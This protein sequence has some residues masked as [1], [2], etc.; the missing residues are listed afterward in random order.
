MNASRQA[1][2]LC[3]AIAVAFV[4][5]IVVSHGHY[6]ATWDERFYLESGRSYVAHFFDMDGLVEVVNMPHL[7]THG[8][9]I[10]GIYAALL[11]GTGEDGSF[12]RLHLVK[13]LCSAL[14]LL[15]VWGAARR[16]ESEASTPVAAMLL[17]VFLPAWS[18]QIYD[19]HMD[20]SA[21]LLYAA[22]ILLA[23]QL[24]VGHAA[25]EQG[26]PPSL[27]LVVGFGAL[28]AIA[29]SHRAPLAVVPGA[30]FLLLAGRAFATGQARRW[31]PRALCFVVVFFLVLWVVDPYLRLHGPVGLFEKLYYAAHAPGV[32]A[33]L[34]RYDGQIFRAA[35]LPRSYLPRWML[36]SIPTMTLALL[37]LGVV[38]LVTRLRR[39]APTTGQLVAAFL[40][41]SLLL[42]LFAAV[43]VK[44]TIFAAWRHFLFL[45][46][47]IA[48]IA[49]LG[50]GQ[51]QAWLAPRW[52][53][54]IA[55]G[56][57]AGLLWIGVGMLRLHPY[58]SLYI[59]A[60][61]GGLPG[62][63]GRF[64]ADYWGRSYKEAAEWIE[65][66]GT[67]GAA[68]ISVH[69]CGPAWVIDY[70]L[71]AGYVL[72]ADLAAADYVVCFMRPGF[73]AP[74]EPPAHTIERDGVPLA[75]VWER[76]TPARD[77]S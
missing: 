6:G 1:R 61:Q 19:N 11:D 40:L 34:V 14:V 56:F 42:P 22:L 20:G 77:D 64:E 76:R 17:L 72:S 9:L 51:L 59:N 46:V 35:D 3:I 36:M 74:S 28:S 39:D 10:D 67:G 13:G 48:I 52:H 62:I 8:G 69:V 2:A 33:L 63:N 26:K 25:S 50:L 66:R 53:S 65:G 27:L 49:G 32:D 58:E 71:P 54:A 24:I 37:A 73:R 4:G 30:C 43:V 55:I 47:P 75:R 70:Y 7:S 45:S 60:L 38:R 18:G 31:L 44:P 23:L 29:F 15:L 5:V 12:E 41:L 16:I 68:A 57:A 21:T